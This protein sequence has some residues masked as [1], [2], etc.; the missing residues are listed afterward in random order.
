MGNKTRRW[1]SLGNNPL[2]TAISLAFCEGP[3]RLLRAGWRQTLCGCTA[4]QK[5]HPISDLDA[6][7]HEMELHG[8]NATSGVAGIQCEMVSMTFDKNVS[9]EPTLILMSRGGQP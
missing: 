8:C 6:T 5:A 9:P 3:S 4:S 7:L 2:T 1:R